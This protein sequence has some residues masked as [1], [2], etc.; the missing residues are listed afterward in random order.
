[1]LTLSIW[2]LSST[3]H[4]IYM[5]FFY[6]WKALS[7]LFETVTQ[8]F[9]HFMLFTCT[10]FYVWKALSYLLET[11]TQEFILHVDSTKT[12]AISSIL[13]NVQV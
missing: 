2:K 9:I 6:V 12:I 1:M 4:V 5:Y 7:Y 13:K 10:F 8:E 3:L 11:V